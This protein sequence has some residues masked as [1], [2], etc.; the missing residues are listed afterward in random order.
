MSISQP[1]GLRVPEPLEI[2][3]WLSASWLRLRAYFRVPEHQIAWS[4]LLLAA[5]LRLSYIDLI[6]FK[7]DEVRHLES[8]RRI[9]H[10]GQF[11]LVG[12]QSSMGPAKPALMSYLLA[13]PMLFSRDPRAA[14]AFIALL[15]LLGVAGLFQF[16]RR[17]YGLRPAALAAL[18]LA[19]N[20]WAIIFSRKIFT[21]DV[22]LP[23]GVLT[24]YGL[25][26]ALVDNDPWGWVM[27]ILGLGIML[28]ITFSPA[29]LIPVILALMLIYRRRVHWRHVLLGFCLATLI[30][31]PYLYHLNITR[32]ADLR[33]LLNGGETEAS[34]LAASPNPLSFATWLHSNR[35]LA[36]LAGASAGEFL[37]QPFA[38]YLD[39]AGQALFLLAVVGVGALAL[40]AWGHWKGQ[41]RPV[42]YVILS[43][44]LWIPLAL[45]LWTRPDWLEM[46]YL[47][48]LYPAGFL[49][50]GLLLDRA[51]RAADGL[52][53]HSQ[54]Y[55]ISAR[56]ALWLGILSFVGWQSYST[57]YL[58]EFV[59]R[60]DTSGGYDLPYR[61][62][63]RVADLARREA[64]AAGTDQVW[65]VTDGTDI[66]YESN[67]AILNYLLEPDI[68]A[69]FLG[70]GGNEC[71][72]LPVGRPGVYL[73]TRTAQ[74]VEDMLHQLQAE[75]RGV[76]IS[77]GGR[78]EAH[79]RVAPAYGVE[80]ALAL[81]QQR[82]L[83]ALDSGLRLIGYDWPTDARAGDT[84]RLAT[85]W[86]FED[87][88]AS[89]RQ[90]QHSLFNHL[91]APDDD[92]VAQRD[93]LGLPEQYWQ[94]GLLL[95]QWVEITLPADLPAGEYALLTGMYRLDDWARSRHI[96]EQGNDLGDAIRLGPMQ[97]QPFASQPAHID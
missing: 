46:H 5:I 21:A 38:Q 30:S 69:I 86:I 20:P 56:F 25:H 57:I 63:L 15:N 59:E 34:A 45:L 12:T 96:D 43:A 72:L 27:T 77:P 55:A 62:W 92:K 79:V 66:A 41:E 93:G 14:S 65:I 7:A 82:G 67:P 36:S 23:F 78:V 29:L 10:Q 4:I 58:Y 81:I 42:K 11:P 89:A 64:R 75:E 49:A 28:N 40:H 37:P 9:V 17:Y 70:Q 50:M 90:A 35:H 52:L 60:Y 48:L 61:F 88:P 19:V 44:W 16:A 76:V 26:R 68:K 91:L 74:P 94:E 2:N 85:Y 73:T 1:R 84:V 8:A 31:V 33:A 83:W 24:L 3:R 71:L 18:L 6:E 53:R 32:L 39:R 51:M 54:W 95:K 47:I 97:V 80:Q 22:L 87:V 13:I